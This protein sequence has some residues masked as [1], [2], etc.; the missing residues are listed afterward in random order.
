MEELAWAPQVNDAHVGVSVLDGVVTLS[1]EVDTFTERVEAKKAALRVT[2]VLVVADEL[3]IR[4]GGHI[5]HTD[6]DIGTAIQHVLEWSADTP[7]GAIKAEVR[8]HVVTL[9]GDVQWNYERSGAERLVRGVVG[10]HRIDNRIGLTPRTS[11]PDTSK[12]IE[13]ALVRHALQDASAITVT[14]G[15]SEVT[16]TGTVSSWAEKKDAGH[17]AWA[18]PHTS[19][20]HNQIVVRP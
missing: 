8:D 2:G 11:A 7:K 16:L 19:A 5:P 3:T 4:D 15:G 20:V 10:V 14:V 1:G 18:S 6:T 13:S 12:L 9:T 17:A